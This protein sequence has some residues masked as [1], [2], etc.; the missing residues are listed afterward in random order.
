M[1]TKYQGKLITCLMFNV[2]FH[3]IVIKCTMT[4]YNFVGVWKIF[5]CK[6]S[7]N[8]KIKKNHSNMHCM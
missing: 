1:R 6:L 3:S 5:T 7:N 4:Y 8:Q 2:L